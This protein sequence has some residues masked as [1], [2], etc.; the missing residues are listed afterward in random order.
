MMRTAESEAYER[1][2]L[3]LSPEHFCIA[4]MSRGRHVE[5][6]GLWLDEGNGGILHSYEG[7]GVVFQSEN[8]IRNTG[9]KNFRY[10][11]LRHETN[12]SCIKPL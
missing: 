7:A 1:W 5:H 8:T 12:S 9:L 10:Y 3:I 6:V 2:Q 11:Q 4:A